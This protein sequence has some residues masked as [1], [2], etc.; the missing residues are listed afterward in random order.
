MTFQGLF[1]RM[2]GRKQ[3]RNRRIVWAQNKGTSIP[4]LLLEENL[5][6]RE[7]RIRPDEE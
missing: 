4:E 6:D 2:A 5:P 7:Y 3:P 1:F